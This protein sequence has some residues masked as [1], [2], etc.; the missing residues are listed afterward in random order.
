M[1][2]DD[3]ARIPGIAGRLPHYIHL[4]GPLDRKGL[5]RE[6][7]SRDRP[8]FEKCL[9]YAVA[10]GILE[11]DGQ[12][13]FRTSAEPPWEPTVLYRCFDEADDLLYV[14]ISRQVKNRLYF[15]SLNSPWYKEVTKVTHQN[16]NSRVEA[17]LAEA[18]AIKIEEPKHNAIRNR[19]VT[20]WI[21]GDRIKPLDPYSEW[22]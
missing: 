7:G 9:E 5:R 16:F 21:K 4:R 14:G 3:P 12:G 20:G 22:T 11:V 10:N 13:F 18:A 8:L 1:K 17:Q 15:H 6:V 19:S 2:L